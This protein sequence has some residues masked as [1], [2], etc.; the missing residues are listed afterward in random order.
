MNI[1]KNELK[2][3]RVGNSKTIP[4]N[5]K[6]RKDLKT[7]IDDNKYSPTRIFESACVSLGFKEAKG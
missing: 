2:I 5:I 3:K 4:I 6:I 7:W 1:D